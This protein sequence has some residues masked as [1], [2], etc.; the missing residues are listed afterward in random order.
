MR[1]LARSR[2]EQRTLNLLGVVQ[3]GRL[4]DRRDLGRGDG[5]ALALGDAERAGVGPD[6]GDHGHAQPIESG[7][8]GDAG[9]AHPCQVR[10]Q[11]CQGRFGGRARLSGRHRRAP[12]GW[13]RDVRP[14]PRARAG[15]RAGPGCRNPRRTSREFSPRSWRAASGRPLR[16]HR[17]AR[18]QAARSSSDFEP[19]LRARLSASPK[20]AS[21]S[22]ARGAD[23]ASS[24]S[25]G[26][27]ATRAARVAKRALRYRRSHAR[28]RPARRRRGRR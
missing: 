25:R 22:S 8:V 1:Q 21:A 11:P 14:W 24:I 15:R 12:A 16:R 17:R 26:G 20:Q 28:P 23:S 10:H 18:L 9:D 4:H 13:A 19:W 5:Q 7:D 27:G 2:P 3:L 6:R